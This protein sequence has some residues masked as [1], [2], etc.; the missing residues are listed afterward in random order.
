MEA[1]S[2]GASEAGGHVIGVTA[3]SVFPHRPHANE[4]VAEEQPA[5]TLPLRVAHLIKISDAA[6]AL[7]GSIGTL[8]E[9]IVAWNTS[10]VARLARNAPYP[11]IAVGPVWHDLAHYLAELLHVDGSLIRHVTNV[12]EAITELAH[13]LGIPR[14]E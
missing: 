10:H 9:L 1:V 8:T 14:D 4:W 3:P 2:R 13:R 6:I 12:D 7:P 11:L 5:A